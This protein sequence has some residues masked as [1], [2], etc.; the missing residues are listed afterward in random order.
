MSRR[1]RRVL[2]VSD[3][4]HFGGA[5]RYVLTLG[6]HF[7][8][9][10]IDVE[11]LWTLPHAEVVTH[12][13]GNTDLPLRIVPRGAHALAWLTAMQAELRRAVPDALIVNASGR[14]RFW[15]VPVLARTMG[16]R[17]AWV[18]HMV[19]TQDHRRLPARLFGG[20]MQGLSWWR[21]P[22]MLRHQVAGVTADA[23]LTSNPVDRD[24]VQRWCGTSPDR[25]HV[26]PPGIDLE[27]FRCDA[28][29]RVGWRRAW[30]GRDAD[31]RL[32]IGT[33]AR[34]VEGKGVDVVIR[35][36]A[37]L[38]RRHPRLAV[39]IAGDGPQRGAL[40]A[41]ARQEGIAERVVFL[42]PAYMPGFYS[43]LD[44]FALCSATESFGLALTEAMACERAVVATPTAGARWQ[45]GDHAANDLRSAAGLLLASADAHVVAEAIDRLLVAPELREELGRRARARAARFSIEQTATATL[46]ALSGRQAS[47]CS[48]SLRLV[49]GG[50][51]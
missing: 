30:L 2:F 40:E 34:L 32:V 50:A 10:N 23:V 1:I 48:E 39:L 27:Q 22:Q 42:K 4:P 20:R 41:L 7:R 12:P 51:S 26:V 18:H 35:A 28:S 16:I 38:A 47:A 44:V 17:V 9:R 11:I 21:V 49:T 36:A 46:L 6:R 3:G 33:A 31:D 24:Y 25:L 14:P 37:L 45:L 29:G 19:D 43:A 13:F 15:L 5:E 8:S